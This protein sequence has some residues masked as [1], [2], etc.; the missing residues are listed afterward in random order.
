MRKIFDAR[1][2]EPVLLLLIALVCML[3]VLPFAAAGLFMVVR[4]RDPGEQPRNWEARPRDI[5]SKR[6][7]IT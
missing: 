1:Y 5:G 3:C 4:S 7:R 6:L 2:G